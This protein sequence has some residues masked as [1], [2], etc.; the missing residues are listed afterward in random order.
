MMSHTK[1]SLKPMS[2][3]GIVV[4]AYVGYRMIVQQKSLQILEN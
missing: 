4:A 1:Q 2:S 3:T